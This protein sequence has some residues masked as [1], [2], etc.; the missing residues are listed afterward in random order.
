MA[1]IVMAIPYHSKVGLAPSLKAVLA[2]GLPAVLALEVVF[3]CV[4]LKVV[5]GLKVVSGLKAVLAVG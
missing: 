3:V 2:L 4:A 5:L 1:F